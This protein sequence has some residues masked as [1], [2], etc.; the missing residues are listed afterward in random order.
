VQLVAAHERGFVTDDN[1]TA[2]LRH[3]APLLIVGAT[4]R[5]ALGAGHFAALRRSC[6]LASVTSGDREFGLNDLANSAVAVSRDEECGTSY[7]LPGGVRVT[8]LAHG[9]P[10]TFFRLEG[11]P[12][13]VSD[14]IYASLLVGASTL[15]SPGHGL[16]ATNST[17]R[18]DEILSTCPLLRDYYRL[19]RPTA[20]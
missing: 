11:L 5:G 9:Y 17:A 10:V 3:H 16:T 13:K 6:C 19:Y 7:T 15:A 1:L 4:G 18:T 2:L 8:V 14:L 20:S 12:N